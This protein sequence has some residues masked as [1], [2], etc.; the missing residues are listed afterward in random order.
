MDKHKEIGEKLKEELNLSKLILVN[1]REKFKKEYQELIVKHKTN[2]DDINKNITEKDKDINTYKQRLLVYHN[3]HKVKE[4]KSEQ[5]ILGMKRE[6]DELTSRLQSTE[7]VNQLLKNE[8]IKEERDSYNRNILKTK[9]RIL[10]IMYNKHFKN[11]E[12]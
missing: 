3:E 12:L 2:I 5:Q 9:H 8:M 7:K 1:E 11:L 10:E 4:E 6:Q